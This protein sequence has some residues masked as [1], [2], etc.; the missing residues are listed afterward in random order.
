[1]SHLYSFA[2][3]LLAALPFQDP[4]PA[5]AAPPKT[6]IPQAIWTQMDN[7]AHQLAKAG[8][9]KEYKHFMAALEELGMPEAQLTKLGAGC[10]S[11]MQKVTKVLESVP[12][13]SKRIKAAVRQIGV[14]M[15]KAP[16]EEKLRLSKILLRLDDSFEEGHKILGHELVGKSWMSAEEKE[17]RGHR[18]EILAAMDKAGRLEVEIESGAS[19]DAPL[20]KFNGQPGVVVKYGAWVFQSCLSEEKTRRIVTE[21]MRAEALSAFLQG[22]EFAVPKK[23]ASQVVHTFYMLD[24]RPKFD[25]A[26]DFCVENGSLTND[27]AKANKDLAGFDDKKSSSFLYGHQEGDFGSIL[28]VLLNPMQTDVHSTT[29]RAGHL[30]W[31]SLAMLGHEIPGFVW[32]N[33]DSGAPKETTYVDNPAER[34][35]R[36]EKYQLARAGILGCR[37]WVAFL[38]E[39]NEDPKWENTFV[40][41]LGKIRGEDL[42]KATTVVEYIQELNLLPDLLKKLRLSKRS[43]RTYTVFNKALAMAV[44]EFEARWRAW[45]VPKN[46]GIA[47]A[48]DKVT[49]TGFDAD[50]ITALKYLNQIRKK[51]FEGR[52]RDVPDLKL[53]RDLCEGVQKHAAYLALNPEQANAW[54]DAHEEYRDKEGYTPEGHWGGTHANVGPAGN[55]PEDAIDG[56]MGTFY[57]RIPMLVPELKR[58]GWGQAGPFAVI[59]VASFVVPPE[60]EWTVVWPADGMKDVP[61][62]F[63]NGSKELPNPVVADPSQNFGYPVTL[64]IGNTK[65]DAPSPQITM[66]LFD[67]KNEVPCWFSTPDKP[68]NPDMALKNSWCLIPKGKLKAGT[69][70]TVTAEWYETGNK[71][72]WTFKTGS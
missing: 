15:E 47:Q 33:K 8:R 69:T 24:S 29:L 55:K 23:G 59:D 32:K 64:Q 3:V 22:K 5:P 37:S 4:A 53:E 70:Y 21:V 41:E 1:M 26:L 38:A 67:G 14:L 30:N 2:L 72:S 63:A 34:K 12:D 10:I 19:D 65:P 61:I 18:G 58:I 39:R 46:G 6:E 31:V 56:W 45:I 7:V 9:E 35:L 49:N 40:D 11:E 20:T 71:I 13:A 48:V 44:T 52:V 54:P 27:E 17:T 50:E 60:G 68:T 25:A 51:A 28:F 16:D 42:L 36:E 43:D 62:D 57:H 66:R